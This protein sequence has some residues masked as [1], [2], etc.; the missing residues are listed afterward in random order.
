[1]SNIENLFK[2]KIPFNFTGEFFMEAPISETFYETDT[3]K[4]S[5][6]IGVYSIEDLFN[7]IKPFIS[8][9]QS[10]TTVTPYRVINL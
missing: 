5:N 10:V 3:I 1:M 6:S 9:L 7:K 8:Y 4:N 2:H